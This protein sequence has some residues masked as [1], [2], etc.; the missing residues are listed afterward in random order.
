MEIRGTDSAKVSTGKRPW[1]LE[2]NTRANQLS[3][4]QNLQ[5]YYTQRKYFFLR[6]CNQ[7]DISPAYPFI[8]RK[9]KNF[10]FL[11]KTTASPLSAQNTDSENIYLALK[12]QK[13]AT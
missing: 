10:E 6:F 3:Q 7:S 8:H 13:S 5:I 9:A 4:F 1:K 11:E 12:S 2:W